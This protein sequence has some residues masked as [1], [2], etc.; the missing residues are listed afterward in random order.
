MKKLVFLFVSLFVVVVA[1]ENVSAQNEATATAQTSATIITPISLVKNV[2]LT[3]GNIVRSST[4]GKVEITPS[5][6]RS[7]SGGASA[8]GTSDGNPAAAQFAVSGEI[9]AL[10]SVQLPNEDVTLTLDGGGATMII[11][12]GS[13]KHNAGD[14]PNIEEGESFNVGATLSVKDNQ[15]VGAY[16]GSFSVTIVYN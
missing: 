6:D 3:F 1:T 14:S 4:A 9:G 10:Y 11:E 13:F 15:T 12:H 16:S 2:D 8:F 7:F 5:G